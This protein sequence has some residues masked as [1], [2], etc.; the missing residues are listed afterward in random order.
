MR[1]RSLLLAC[2]FFVACSGSS[3]A[4]DCFKEYWNGEVGTCLPQGWRVLDQETMRQRGVPDDA[5]IAFQSETPISGQFLT[6]TVTREQLA[7]TL[8]PSIY[9]QANIRLVSSL[10]GYT[11]VDSTGAN[12]DGNTVDLHIFTAQPVADEPPRRFYQISTVAN[13]IGYSITA[14]SPVSVDD[15][16][17][18]QLINIVQSST[19]MA[20]AE[21][22]K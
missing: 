19:F 13:S 10:P 17:E 14:T 11:L 8:E 21:E 4:N 5:I 22:A 3:T 12:I 2:L 9:S 1:Y 18:R 15:V 6:V 7:D 20:K 16:T